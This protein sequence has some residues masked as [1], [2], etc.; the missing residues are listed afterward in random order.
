MFQGDHPDLVRVMAGALDLARELHH[1][2][3][4]SEHLLLATVSAGGTLGASFGSFGV[5]DSSLLWA[6]SQAAP[7]GAGAAIDRDMLAAL[8]I[9]LDALISQAGPAFLDQRAARPPL[10]PCGAAS[11]RNRC[12][13]SAPPIGLDAQATYEASLRLALARR[14]RVHRPEHLAF[15]LVAVDPGAGWLLRS[16]AVDAGG[17]LRALATALPSRGRNPLIK[18]DRRIGRRWRCNSILRRYQNTTGRAPTAPD[19][20]SSAILA[21]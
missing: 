20:V 16:I 18:A 7:Q 14:D 12:A 5:T 3:C 15:T 8:G 9:D 2:R 4:G 11:A 10:L 21:T 13:A 17:L 6:M 1:P 19:A